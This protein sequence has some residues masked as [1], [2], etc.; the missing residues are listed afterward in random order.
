MIL[1][2]QNRDIAKQLVESADDGMIL[3]IRK[4]KRSLEQN[5]YY[6]AILTDISEQVVPGKAYEPSIWHEYLRALML[7]ERVIELPDGSIKM[8][9]ASTAELR[10]DEFS[11]Y[12]E[13]VIKWALE[14]EVRFSDHTKSLDVSKQKAA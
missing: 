10:K 11:E 9:E 12:I 5:R 2:S 1:T 3:E 4:P 8:V 6:W 7:P 14:H 13:K